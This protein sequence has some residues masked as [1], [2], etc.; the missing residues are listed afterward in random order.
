M[1]VICCFFWKRIY[2]SK[3]CSYL[4]V[5]AY[6]QQSCWIVESSLGE[7]IYYPAGFL[8]FVNICLFTAT[9][10]KLCMYGRARNIR[11]RKC[12]DQFGE[13][14]DYDYYYG[15]I[16]KYYILDDRQDSLYQRGDLHK[17]LRKIN[18]VE[19]ELDY[20]NY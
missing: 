18:N 10:V 12:N 3:D 17:S 15:F 1:C 5:P 2:T 19:N 4:A 6:G 8:L 16:T 14:Y 13:W 11:A 20:M 9:C 7:Y